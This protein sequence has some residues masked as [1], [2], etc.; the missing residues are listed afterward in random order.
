[1]NGQSQAD[2]FTPHVDLKLTDEAFQKILKFGVQLQDAPT[3]T[4]WFQ[5]TLICLLNALLREYR[6]LT[7]GFKKSTPLLA[8]ACRNMLELN[9]YTKYV[10]L[11]GSNAKDF[12]DDMWLDAIEIFSS[13]RAWFKFHDPAGVMPELDQTIANLQLEKAR[14]GITRT[15]YLRTQNMAALVNSTEEYLYMNKVASK[16]VHPTAFSVL[17]ASDQGELGNLRPIF[18]SAGVRYGV[19]AFNEIREYVSRNR[20]EPPPE[21]I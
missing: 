20:V 7:L 10:L 4:I 18:F 14:Q 2:N 17:T 8:W 21:K 9:I 11:N 15:S 6:S 1:M 13:F 5:N 16:L 3:Q 19:E 12:A